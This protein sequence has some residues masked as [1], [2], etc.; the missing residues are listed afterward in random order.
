MLKILHVVNVPW[1]N[2][3]AWYALQTAIAQKQHG[4]SVIVA[5]DP[6]SPSVDEAERL[7]MGPGLRLPFSAPNP[8]G[9]WLASRGLRSFIEK[10]AIDVVNAHQGNGYFFIARAAR[11]AKP[12]PL[13]VRTRGD[14]RPIKRH[15]LNRWL[16]GQYS[17]GVIA[18]AQC[19]YDRLRSDLRLS[20]AQCCWIPPA[21][22]T[23]YFLPGK[24]PQNPIVTF[25]LV[26]RIDN[27]KGH[28]LAFAAFRKLS[29][30]GRDFRVLVAG[31]ESDLSYGA[32]R[33]AAREQGLESR[34][35][36]LGRVPDIREVMQRCD[37]GIIPSTASEAVCRVAL[38]FSAMD[39]PV[40]ASN[41]N[42]I[43][44]VVKEGANGLLFETGN[45]EALFG[46]LKLFMEQGGRQKFEPRKYVEARHSFANLADASI[47][48][49]EQLRALRT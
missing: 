32:L 11:S 41:L 6:G 16:Y 8:A 21:V 29:E 47:G 15:F 25:G 39:V 30:T 17:H 49:Y 22:D 18:A 31:P 14:V 7:G 38:E 43:P 27:K 40:I 9:Q 5:G 45:A 42:G 33:S 10:N 13:L 35:E 46:C 1:Y 4:H 20:N 3:V 34:I 2:A 36:F 23:T 28:L 37:A 19:I 26:G 12:A 44:D 24:K 48:F